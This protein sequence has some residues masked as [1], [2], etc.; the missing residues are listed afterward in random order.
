MYRFD[1]DLNCAEVVNVTRRDDFSLD[2]PAIEKAVD[3][4][5][6]N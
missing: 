2:L 6:P 5:I 3:V 4:Y 1:G